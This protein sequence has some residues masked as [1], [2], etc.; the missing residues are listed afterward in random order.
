MSTSSVLGCPQSYTSLVGLRGN[1]KIIGELENVEGVTWDR[2]MNGIGS[3]T[4]VIGVNN[5]STQCCRLL[6]TLARDEN[7]GAYEMHLYRDS[8]EVWCGP[9]ELLTETLGPTAHQAVVSARDILGYLD[10]Y[11]HWLRTGYNLTADVVD[12]ATTILGT[13]LQTDDPAIAAHILATESGVVVSRAAAAHSATVYA[14]L[15][16]LGALG[17]RFTTAVRTLYL[18]GVTGTPFG[19]PIRMSVDQIAGDITVEHRAGAYVNTVFGRSGTASSQVP[20]GQIPAD[21]PQLVTVG[22]PEP[23]WRGRMETCVTPAGGSNGQAAVVAAAQ[24]AYFAARRPRLL[25]VADG[26]VLS[27]D[28]TVTVDQLVCGT[29]VKLAGREEFCT[30]VD[31]DLQ[32]TRVAGSFGQDGERIGISLGPVG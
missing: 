22:G 24:A 14:E 3:A 31:Q 18:G 7:Q 12:I 15:T 10:N 4:T 23:G 11:G 27:P 8:T 30:W 19:R 21:D 32:L 13:D 20:A 9:I 1:G 16:A 2:K 26:A 6:N 5:V 17:L 25:R 28:A 29:V